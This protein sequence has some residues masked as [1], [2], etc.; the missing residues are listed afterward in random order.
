VVGFD[1]KGDGMGEKPSLSE[2]SV[3]AD[4][5]DWFQVKN[6]PSLDDGG[7]DLGSGLFKL[8]ALSGVSR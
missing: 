7:G 4:V 6:V 2:N 3:E 1:E 8:S 5:G